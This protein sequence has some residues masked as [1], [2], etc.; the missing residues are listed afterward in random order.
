MHAGDGN[1]H[2]RIP[3]NSNDYTVMRQA[4]GIIDRVMALARLLDGVISGEHGIGLTRM[5]YMDQSVTQAF[6]G[7]RHAIDP[8]G[9][10]NRGKLMPGSGLDNAC[11]PSLRL[12]Q[13][14]ALILEQSD[15]G[16]LAPTYT[17]LQGNTAPTKW[18][19]LNP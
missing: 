8:H 18:S 17:S 5:Q 10:F 6:A 16:A 9:H 7:F 14:E 4:E 13:Q 12:V 19:V 3:V 1:I 11:T 15:P 2:T